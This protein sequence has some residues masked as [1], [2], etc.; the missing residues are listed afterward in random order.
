[1]PKLEVKDRKMATTLAKRVE[2]LEKEVDAL[3]RLLLLQ[4]QAKVGAEPHAQGW[5]STVGLFND[6]PGFDEVVRLGRAYR[7]RQPKC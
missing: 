6:D 3:K 2:A 4:P 7:R 1:M 5:Q